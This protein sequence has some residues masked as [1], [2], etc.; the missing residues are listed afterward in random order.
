MGRLT[1]KTW[2]RAVA[3]LCA[4]A[5]SLAAFAHRTVSPEPRGTDPQIAAYLALGGSLDELCLADAPGED[6]AAHPDCPA[7]ALSKALALGPSPA[8]P[9]G[10]LATCTHATWPDTPHLSGHAPCA[11][12]ARGPPPLRLT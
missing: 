8:G 7:C 12:P 10:P 9:A 5:L 6:G 3:V 4:L 11:P 2:T 1:T